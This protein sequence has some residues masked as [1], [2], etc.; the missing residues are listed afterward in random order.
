VLIQASLNGSRRPGDH[1]A[2]PLTPAELASD[3][4]QV[5][6][7]GARELHVHPRTPDGRETLDPAACDEALL[8]IRHACPG[9][10]VGVSAAAWIEPE[11]ARREASIGSWTERPN[12]VSVNF[13]EEG[14][15]D[16]C[17]LL[18]DCGIGIE[19]AVWTVADVEA[20]LASGFERHIVRVVVEPQEADPLQAEAA[21]DRISTALDRADL[22]PRLFH[23]FGPATWRII[24][25][26]LEGAWDIRA[27]LEDTLT[28]PDG[29]P[30]GGNVDLVHAAVRMARK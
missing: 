23:G 25:Y 3:A 4:V 13:A 16:L 22:T 26:A 7:A 27:G 14:V 1:P 8:A 15:V 28:L 10:P 12:F 2:L 30:A 20:L 5:F 24:E 11:P 9:M 19:A 6:R 29:R 18:H 21:A 17:R